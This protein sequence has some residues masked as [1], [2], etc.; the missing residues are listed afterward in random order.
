MLQLLL[1]F[2]INLTVEENRLVRLQQL[3]AHQAHV[4]PFIA[5]AQAL[6]ELAAEVVDI[7]LHQLLDIR[8]GKGLGELLRRLQLYIAHKLLQKLV[9]IALCTRVEAD[10]LSLHHII[11][12]SHIVHAEN[13]EER[14]AHDTRNLDKLLHL[15]VQRTLAQRQA[16]DQQQEYR[17]RQ[18]KPVHQA[19]IIP[20]KVSI[21]YRHNRNPASIRHRII[22]A[23]L[24]TIIVGNILHLIR[25]AAA[26]F[27]KKLIYIRLLRF[28]RHIAVINREHDIAVRVAEIIIAMLRQLIIHQQHVE[29]LGINIH[30]QHIISTKAHRHRQHAL[31]A[32]AILIKIRIGN[33]IVILQ[34]RLIPA[35]AVH[36]HLLLAAASAYKA[37][38]DNSAHIKACHLGITL[39]IFRKMK[40]RRLQLRIAHIRLHLLHPRHA[41]GST[42]QQHLLPLEAG[43]FLHRK[44]R[45]QL[46]A[47][48]MRI[49]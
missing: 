23:A 14:A 31:I 37:A 45:S 29:P 30:R 11:P 49:F 34:R 9:I 5:L 24:L 28:N 8:A 19:L 27:L 17:Q 39:H 15:L 6:A 2:L 41:L 22:N 33:L 21:G 35:Q 16:A 43:S 1:L 38:I 25:I 26:D 20:Q 40:Q 7:A 32:L 48:N 44:M 47:H 4:N 13:S 18:R 10:I 12:V 36:I 42:A 3:V 46:T